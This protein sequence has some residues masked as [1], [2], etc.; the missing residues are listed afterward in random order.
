MTPLKPGVRLDR[1][2]LLLELGRGGMASVWVARETGQDQQRLV[3]LKI[4]LPRLAGDSAFRAMFLAE[5][6]L[7]RSIE[8]ENVVRVFAVGE[9]RGLLYL[10][11]EWVEG[12]SLRT[13]IQAA[14]E[15]RAIPPEMAVRIIADTAAGLHAAHEL[16]GWDGELRGIV[17][18]DV[19]PHN[20]LIGPAG[21]ARLVDFGV[22]HA[23]SRSDLEEEG[24]LRGKLGYMSPEQA[25]GRPLDR[26]T[27]VF[28]LGIVLYELTTGVRLFRGKDPTQTL[29]LV[30]HGNIPPPSQ[31]VPDYPPQLAQIVLRALERDV[32]R[33]FQTANELR[34]ALEGYLVEELILVSH[35]GVGA[36]VKRVLGPRIQQRRD[37]IRVALG[38]LGQSAAVNNLSTSDVE[39]SP[40]PLLPPGA[41]NGVFVEPQ[42]GGSAQPVA[43]FEPTSVSAPCASM[44]GAAEL[45]V[46]P[47][48]VVARRRRGM[49]G[50]GLASLLLVALGVV[51]VYVIVTESEPRPGQGR[52]TISAIDVAQT[53]ADASDPR[54]ERAPSGAGESE[55]EEAPASVDALPTLPNDPVGL[56][57]RQSRRRAV[58]REV[59]SAAV[60]SSAAAPAPEVGAGPS[61]EGAPLPEVE[62][63][64]FV[65]AIVPP[66]AAPDT[67]GVQ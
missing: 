8:H 55:R 18:C 50:A 42:P 38:R 30:V 10:A 25:Q 24:Q 66:V 16:R 58:P 49:L 61:P 34:A 59:A 13:V 2:E 45:P 27:D 64:G 28:A 1:Y 7:V 17:H 22:A 47:V 60:A 67:P 35:A 62:S 11:M 39:A 19:S 21:R 57:A 33:R 65:P 48:P 3:A 12:D 56:A 29:A 4:M 15:R 36:L 52:P 31:L 53:P 40:G 37:A 51:A 6:Q 26:R 20:I 23:A 54:G 14:K 9:A 43:E 46:E 5:G 63:G 44:P 32:D 41:V